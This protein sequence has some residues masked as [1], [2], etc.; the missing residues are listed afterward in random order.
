MSYAV[1]EFRLSSAVAA[2]GTVEI[3]YP[4]G[5]AQ[6]D[7]K[8]SGAHFLTVSGAVLSSADSEFSVSFGGSTITLTNDG[9]GQPT[10][11][12]DAVIRGQFDL[13]AA[14]DGVEFES[15]YVTD[16]MEVDGTIL[17]DGGVTGDL[18]G[19]VT[20]NVTGD[21]TGDLTGAVTGD[22]SG[23]VTGDVTGNVTGDLTGQVTH[24]DEPLSTVN[25]GTANTGVT[26][27]EEGNGVHNRTTLT[28]SQVDALTLADNDAIADGYLLYTFP[29]GKIVIHSASMSMAVSAASAELQADTPDVG[30]GTV[31]AEGAVATLDGTGTFEDIVTG[32]TAA[33]ANGTETLKTATP[34]GGA[35]FVMESADAHTLHFNVADT[36]ADDTGADLTADISGTV[37]IEWS[38]LGA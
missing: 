22:V 28:V 10:W 31:I 3:P 38:F 2:S 4:T 6:A 13:V 34:T 37:I 30:L 25:N 19:D 14:Q 9:S 33:D 21:V 18:T 1:N 26:A 8:A 12:K 35:P 7:F 17:A 11:P 15:I 23:D 20:G 27:V 5:T 16:D 36:W 24:D 29:A 32:Q